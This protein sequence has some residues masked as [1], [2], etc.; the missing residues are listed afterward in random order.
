MKLG[1]LF[2][3]RVTIAASFALMFAGIA[4]INCH[5]ADALPVTAEAAY[6]TE[7]LRCVDKATTLTESRACRAKVQAAWTTDAG[8]E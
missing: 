4:I 1:L 5:P 8:A 6:L 3:D 2:W 7:Q